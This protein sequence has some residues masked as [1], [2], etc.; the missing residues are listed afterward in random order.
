MEAGDE[1][2]ESGGERELVTNGGS[3]T[4]MIRNLQ[5]GMEYTLRVISFRTDV[6][7]GP[8]SNEVLGVP[9][10]PPVSGDATL[11][12]LRVTETDGT[13][14][15]LSPSMFSATVTSYSAS[16]ANPVSRVT[17]LPTTSHTGA[18]IHY[19]DANDLKLDDADDG[20]DDF[21]ADLAVG[22]NTVKVKIVAETIWPRKPIRS[23]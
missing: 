16:V 17:I 15:T 4:S 12:D 11:S 3:T 8:P 23:P 1:G 20:S 21:Q 19:L 7:E 13:A 14:V 2:F 18:E 9:L 10:S 6:G 5:A 22:A